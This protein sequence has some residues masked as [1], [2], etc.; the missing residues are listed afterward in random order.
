MENEQQE[1]PPIGASGEYILPHLKR[2]KQ[3]AR[4]KA[5]G[6]YAVVGLV[7][8]GAAG[9]IG[10]VVLQGAG[11]PFVAGPAA[12]SSSSEGP[13]AAGYHV[14]LS[15]TYLAQGDT[16]AALNEARA[17][18]RAAP[19]NVDALLSLASLTYAQGEPQQ[20][21]DLLDQAV[22]L[23]PKAVDPILARA[24]L[25]AKIGKKQDAEES[26]IAAATKTPQEARFRV[27]LA[28]LYD[29]TNE[30]DKAAEQYAAAVSL[31]PGDIPTRT[32]YAALLSRK[33]DAAGAEAQRR[34]LA[35]RYAQ[36]G[37][38][39]MLEGIMYLQHNQ[40]TEALKALKR[41]VAVNN[42]LIA[43]HR[44]IGTIYGKRKQYD[45]AIKACEAAVQTGVPDAATY[46]DLAWLY[47]MRHISLD[48]AA[49]LAEMAR[50]M[51]PDNLTT[52]DTL[53]WVYYLEGQYDRALPL[54]DKAVSPEKVSPE[55][56][57]H[58]GMVLV[59]LGRVGGAENLRQAVTAA[60]KASWAADAQAELARQPL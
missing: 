18:V 52:Y 60:P 10:I 14:A 5:I 9:G 34:V 54:L 33:G 7:L 40:D 3:L 38:A 29:E 51:A 35:S 50:A 31:D 57:Y 17:A 19:R 48:K 11:P 15:R 59:K 53:G 2:E 6:T 24:E 55:T 21:V 56:R 4:W 44:L 42:R 46:N 23:A 27:A 58:Y 43:A 45:Q 13:E 30:L 26:L 41:A 39:E 49:R 28:E 32:S 47:A 1:F 20:A 8:A 16:D 22:A 12:K 25:L 37:A 36:T